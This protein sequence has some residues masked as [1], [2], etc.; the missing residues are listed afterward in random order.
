[1]EEK[2]NYS[3]MLNM[4]IKFFFSVFFSYLNSQSHDEVFFYDK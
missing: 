3:V 1:M 4:I 2:K